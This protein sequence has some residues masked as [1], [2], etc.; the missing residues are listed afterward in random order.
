MFLATRSFS[1]IEIRGGHGI[2]AGYGELELDGSYEGKM[3]YIKIS[4]MMTVGFGAL[5]THSRS[6]SIPN[7]ILMCM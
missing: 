3:R 6:K 1:L 2:W 7:A 4:S 5:D